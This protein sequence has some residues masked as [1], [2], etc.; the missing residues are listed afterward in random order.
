M[1]ANTGVHYPR[2]YGSGDSVGAG[3]MHYKGG[4]GTGVREA[5]RVGRLW[6]GSRAGF[7]CGYLWDVPSNAWW[8]YAAAV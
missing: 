5:L 4:T 1:D 2:A 7:S 3:D 6:G 8:D